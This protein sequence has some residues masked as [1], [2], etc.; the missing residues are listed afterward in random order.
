[1]DCLCFCG[2][3]DIGDEA[4]ESTK[5]AYKVLICGLLVS[6]AALGGVKFFSLFTG[7]AI[8]VYAASIALLTAL[9]DA[10]TIAYCVKWCAEYKK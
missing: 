1:M 4:A 2:L 3:S 9:L 7:M 5:T 6:I 8:S 10:A